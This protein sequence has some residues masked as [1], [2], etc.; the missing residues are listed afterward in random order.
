[1]A[2]SY[3]A[4]RIAYVGLS[5]VANATSGVSWCLTARP[6][7]WLLQTQLGDDVRARGRPAP[8]VAGPCSITAG[9]SGGGTY[10]TFHVGAFHR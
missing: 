4:V 5:I 9:C 3:V 1:M 2:R 10:C 6:L 8:R 7:R